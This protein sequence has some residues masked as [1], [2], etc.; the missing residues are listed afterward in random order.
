MAWHEECLAVPDAEFPDLH[1]EP[2][3]PLAGGQ[4]PKLGSTSGRHN[5]EMI[6]NID[7][8]LLMQD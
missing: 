4:W 8:N 6:I 5:P 1:G 7:Y 3:T 2:E